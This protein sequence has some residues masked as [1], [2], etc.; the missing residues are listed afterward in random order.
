MASNHEEN[1]SGARVKRKAQCACIPQSRHVES[2][3]E[4]TSRQ[5]L[6]NLK[7]Q[8]PIA[9]ANS[10]RAPP[11]WGWNKFPTNEKLPRRQCLQTP[12]H[13]PL[14]TA[15]SHCFRHQQ[16]GGQLF[17]TGHKT[18]HTMTHGLTYTAIRLRAPALSS[19]HRTRACPRTR[20]TL[21]VSSNR[22]YSY[23]AKPGGS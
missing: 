22:P 20:I 17:W 9:P 7:H 14:F 2:K 23:T 6:F 16:L 8:I 4:Q 18:N 3:S 12:N 13:S 10:Y 11:S 1:S 19:P 21:H 5:G 15:K